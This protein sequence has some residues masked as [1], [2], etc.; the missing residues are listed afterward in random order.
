MHNIL[1]I[2]LKRKLAQSD[3]FSLSYGPRRD[4]NPEFSQIW[5]NEKTADNAMVMYINCQL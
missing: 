1:K 5:K 3:N 2:N 4:K